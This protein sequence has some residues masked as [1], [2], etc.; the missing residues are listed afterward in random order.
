M[1]AD[2]EVRKVF[3]KLLPKEFG[4][5]ASRFDASKCTVVLAVVSDRPGDLVIPF[6]SRLNLKHVAR[7][8]RTFG[9]ELAIAKI[10]VADQRRALQRFISE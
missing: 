1:R 5:D 7:R 3:G 2:L 6:F 10:E 9:Y 4:F 8:I